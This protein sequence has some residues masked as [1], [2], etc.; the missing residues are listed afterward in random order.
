MGTMLC[1]RCLELTQLAQLKLRTHW[2]TAPHFPLPADPSFL[3]P[4][5]TAIN[6]TR[7]WGS[8]VMSHNR[9]AGVTRERK[10]VS[11]RKPSSKYEYPR[12]TSYRWQNR[13]QQSQGDVCGYTTGRELIPSPVPAQLRHADGRRQGWEGTTNHLWCQ[14]WKEVWKGRNAVGAS[15]RRR[16]RLIIWTEEGIWNP[17]WYLEDLPKRVQ[18]LKGQFSGKIN[19]GGGDG[20]TLEPRADL[21]LYSLLYVAL[22]RS[23]SH[24]ASFSVKCKYG[25]PCSLLEILW[26]FNEIMNVKLIKNLGFYPVK[27][28]A[29]NSRL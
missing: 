4:S 28:C 22:G 1:S 27:A 8:K 3:S 13:N 24:S 16:K 7:S 14:S 12:N 10:P 19:E 9:A 15:D 18:T 11:W 25:Q 6:C 17:G 23:V 21:V 26:G 5:H 2:G 29:T 20:K